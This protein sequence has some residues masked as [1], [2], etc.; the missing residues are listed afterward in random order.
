MRSGRA[1]SLPLRAVRILG[2]DIGAKRIGLALSDP[3]GE[4][5]F[6]AGAL[7]RTARKADLA[8]LCELAREH[9]VGQIVLGLPIHM[10]G[11]QGPEAEAARSFASDLAAR[12]G[13]PVELID[14]RWTSIEAE[15][16]LAETGRSKRRVRRREPRGDVD[17]V[18]ASLILRTWLDRRAATAGP[19]GPAR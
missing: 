17:A 10:D 11:R 2:L 16:S 18:A 19:S 8:A 6:P 4:Y 14:E 1:G 7:E 12:S 13:L 9:E 5:A 15:R 3:A